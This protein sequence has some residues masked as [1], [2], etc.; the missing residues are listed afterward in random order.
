MKFGFQGWT[1]VNVG[2][3]KIDLLF[4]L[5]RVNIVVLMFLYKSAHHRLLIV[6][7]FILF[8]HVLTN[9]RFRNFTIGC[10]SNTQLLGSECPLIMG[11]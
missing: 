6:F 7:G 4:E 5:F 11:R 10:R 2:I 8:G 3:R 9:V 1:T